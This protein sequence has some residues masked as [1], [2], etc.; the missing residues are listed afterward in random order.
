MNLRLKNKND[1]KAGKREDSVAG[2]K[3]TETV[4]LANNKNQLL[5]ISQK[6]RQNHHLES[7]D[8]HRMNKIANKDLIKE[9]TVKV[10]HNGHSRYAPSR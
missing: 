8:V 1:K 3:K 4:Y 2:K 10:V 5:H 9:R 7:E 6:Q